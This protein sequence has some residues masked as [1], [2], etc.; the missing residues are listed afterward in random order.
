MLG[1]FTGFQQAVVNTHFVDPAFEVGEVVVSPADEQLSYAWR[2]ARCYLSGYL[3]P[4]PAVEIDCDVSPPPN[5]D[6]VIKRVDRK[7]C[8]TDQGIVQ[9]VAVK[10]YQA[11][12]GFGIACPANAQ[13]IARSSVDA[14]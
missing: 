3:G 7:L 5:E 4:G 2:A 13:V 8:L 9:L 6:Y 1:D 11:T 10:E 14:V 12:R